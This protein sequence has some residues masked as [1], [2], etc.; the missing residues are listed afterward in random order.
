MHLKAT[1]I[2]AVGYLSIWKYNLVGLPSRPVFDG[3]TGGSRPGFSTHYVV[4]SSC[5]M[6]VIEDEIVIVVLLRTNSI[7]I[8]I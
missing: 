4:L 8:M 7:C 1:A 2:L 3:R 6:P 5:C